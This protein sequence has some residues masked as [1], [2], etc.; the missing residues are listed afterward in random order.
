MQSPL[1]SS[2]NSPSNSF[3]SF[4]AFSPKSVLISHR[5]SLLGISPHIPSFPIMLS[6]TFRSHRSTEVE[7][8][9]P[10]SCLTVC[11]QMDCSSPG[12]S[13]PGINS[14]GKDTGLGSHSL[15]PGDLS[16]PGI[17]PRC[18]ALQAN[19]LLSEPPVHEPTSKPLLK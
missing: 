16:D 12:S 17:K 19:S 8:L 1:C 7:V 14:P 5:P 10:Q 13:V 6:P 9:V 3:P 4:T 11:D 15:S 2:L 18:P